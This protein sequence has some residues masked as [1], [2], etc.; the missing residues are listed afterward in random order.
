MYTDSVFFVMSNSLVAPPSGYI[1][2]TQPPGNTRC[3]VQTPFASPSWGTFR[4]PIPLSGTGSFDLD[5]FCTLGGNCP[6]SLVGDCGFVPG[7]AMARDGAPANTAISA[8]RLGTGATAL[9]SA[10]SNIS[11][12]RAAAREHSSASTAA[13]ESTAMVAA[14]RRSTGRKLAATTALSYV[15]RAAACNDVSVQLADACICLP[16]RPLRAA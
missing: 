5:Q 15:S 6:G 4:A 10:Y 12:S 14:Q 3:M 7:F 11:A 2:G 13:A 16:A 8:A 9:R 1:N